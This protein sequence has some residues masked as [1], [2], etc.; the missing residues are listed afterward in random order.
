MKN[1]LN[2]STKQ[3]AWNVTKNK[4]TWGVHISV[5]ELNTI[6]EW[7][8]SDLM[9]TAHSIKITVTHNSG[10]GGTV[11]AYALDNQGEQIAKKDVTD[12]REW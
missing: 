6:K 12:Y 3:L 10:I 1:L 2:L 4:K 5:A 7:L 8:D 9:M 11:T